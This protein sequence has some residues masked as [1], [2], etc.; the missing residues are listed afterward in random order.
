MLLKNSESGGRLN[1]T[2]HT[3]VFFLLRSGSTRFEALINKVRG[4]QKKAKKDIVV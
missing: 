3:T 2:L 1:I 4:T